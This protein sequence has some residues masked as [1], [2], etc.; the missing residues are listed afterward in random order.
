MNPEEALQA[1]REA[2]ARARE[3]GAYDDDLAGFAIEP[4]DRVSMEQLMDWAVIE[5][6]TT[7]MRST[8][9]LGAPITSLKRMLLRALQQ[10]HNEITSQQTRF[11]L[12]VMVH[13]A[14]LEDRLR[15]LEE[16]ERP[17]GP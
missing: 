14:E 17:P 5:P 16:R 4:T 7:L 1:A 8:R 3:R 9:K 2:A 11:N 15:R 12:H 13:V 6:D 10:Y